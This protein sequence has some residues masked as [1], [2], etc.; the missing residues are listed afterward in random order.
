VKPPAANLEEQMLSHSAILSAAAVALAG[1]YL[2][3]KICTAVVFD[4]EPVRRL[5]QLNT[6]LTS[7][8]GPQQQGA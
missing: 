7:A 8:D 2:D 1:P 3:E 6:Y 4:G 5:A